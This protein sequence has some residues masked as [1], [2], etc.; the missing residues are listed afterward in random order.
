MLCW[1][2]NARPI[3]IFN[4]FIFDTIQ[5]I[6]LQSP[7][8]Q[9]VALE[10]FKFNAFGLLPENV[11][12]SM[13]CSDTDN[14]MIRRLAIMKKLSIRKSTTTKRLNKIPVIKYDAVHWYE[15][16]DLSQPGICEPAL[17]ADIA[18][19]ILSDAMEKRT[20]LQLP[21][22]PRHSQSVERA[23]K[24][25]SEASHL[26]YMDKKPDIAIWSL[27]IAADKLDHLLLP[28]PPIR[29]RMKNFLS[30]KLLCFI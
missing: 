28:K 30:K 12:Y 15:L 10:N 21:V 14:M 8:I 18:T 26:V 13:I 23:V 2:V 20:K 7:T 4:V 17:T 5:R 24:L 25:T 29:N 1:D 6:K 27:S 19:E 3:K 9:K 11:L 16:I 22:L